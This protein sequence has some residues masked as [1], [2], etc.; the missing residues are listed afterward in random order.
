MGMH[1]S[2]MKPAWDRTR[3]R[4]QVCTN[5]GRQAHYR[6]VD[7]GVLYHSF[8]HDSRMDFKSEDDSSSFAVL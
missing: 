8:I 2:R 7:R 4:V 5:F 1:F 6:A 3:L